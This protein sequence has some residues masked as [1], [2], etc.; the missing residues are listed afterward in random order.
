MH[1]LGGYRFTT[2]GVLDECLPSAAK[3]LAACIKSKST[4]PTATITKNSEAKPIL[5]NRW[6][7]GAYWKFSF[8]VPLTSK[9]KYDL[10]Q[11][12]DFFFVNFHRDNA[13]DTRYRDLS[14]NSIKFAIWPSFSIGPTL[15]LLFYQNKVNRD[16]LFQK[17]F[18]LEATVS[19][20]L[21]NSREKAVQLKHKP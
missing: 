17:Q 14:R 6:R 1:A 15:Q 16:F 3:T 11:E 18:G 9:I 13:T 20:D 10:T 7:A 2:Q 4:P 19:F 21:F 8:S 12:A 5:E